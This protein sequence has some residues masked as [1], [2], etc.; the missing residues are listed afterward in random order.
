VGLDPG[1][2]TPEAAAGSGVQRMR[3]V[4]RNE[5]SK[6]LAHAEWEARFPRLSCG[7]TTALDADYGLTRGDAGTRLEAYTTLGA[8]LGFGVVAVGRQ[9]HGTDVRMLDPGAISGL[10]LAGSVDGVVTARAGLLLAAT[11]AD[12]VPVY[13]YDPISGTLGLL[14]AGWRGTAGGVLGQGVQALSALGA[15]RES[16]H[17]HLGPAICGACYEVDTPVLRALGLRGDRGH[18]DLRAVLSDQARGEGIAES[19]VSVSVWCTRCS[20]GLLH[21]HR[22]NGSAAGRMAAYL[23]RKVPGDGGSGPVR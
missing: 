23:G 5:L 19:H 18:V 14:H 4:P 20:Q 17:L 3:E 10:L 9:V 7:I 22:G 2:T 16:I 6:D 13:L 8:R 21:S 1:A 12:C 11:A 15:A